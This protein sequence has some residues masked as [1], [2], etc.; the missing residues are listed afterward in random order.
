MR[1]SMITARIPMALMHVPSQTGGAWREGALDA[2]AVALRPA[3]ST[4]RACG[5]RI[6]KALHDSRRQQAAHEIAR[7]RHLL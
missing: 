3:L 6:L 2:M 7:H 4:A 5:A 1:A